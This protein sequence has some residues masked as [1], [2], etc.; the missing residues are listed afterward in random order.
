MTEWEEYKM[1]SFTRIQTAVTN[2]VNASSLSS[3][4]AENKLITALYLAQ[5]SYFKFDKICDKLTEFG[6]INLSLY[7]K[8]GTQ[9]YCA[10][11]DD[12]VVVAFRGTE[13]S[14]KD[15]L[16]KAMTFWKIPFENVMVHKGFVTSLRRL[17][18]NI[19]SDLE[20]IDTNKRI[21]YTGH[22]LGGAIATL[23]SIARKP[24]ELCTF[25]APKVAGNDLLEH[26]AN[27]E[28]NRIVTTKDWIRHLPPNIP[29]ILP[30]SH[31]GTE[32]I[33]PSDWNWK[34][35]ARPHLLVTYLNALLDQIEAESKDT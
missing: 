5:L 16:R 25:G 3:Q 27:V 10:E 2:N 35:V 19:L 8:K 32:H 15:D 1:S 24:D 18:P 28:Y 11:F 14:Q 17:L 13:L 20:C 34:S 7:N 9:G 4:L 26:F 31:G 30:Y 21:L 22:S 33:L 23:L 12:L 29:N 6:A